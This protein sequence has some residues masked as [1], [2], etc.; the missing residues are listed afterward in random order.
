[1]NSKEH[2]LN[3]PKIKIFLFSVL[4][5]GTPPSSNL[6]TIIHVNVIHTVPILGLP[7]ARL[8]GPGTTL[9]RTRLFVEGGEEVDD[10]LLECLVARL[11]QHSVLSDL[12]EQGL[13]GGLNVLG[14]LLL[15]ES[16]LCGVHLVQ[17]S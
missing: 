13:V 12:V 17:V 3:A 10:D 5:T 14:E 4:A 7:W 15:E 16:D 6:K 2:K 1:L 11:A 8:G 9:G